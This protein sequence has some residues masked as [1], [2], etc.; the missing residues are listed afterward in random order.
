MK[1]QQ[2]ILAYFCKLL[3]QRNSFPCAY[4]SVIPD[5]VD[6]HL[7]LKAKYLMFSF[8]CTLDKNNSNSLCQL[9]IKE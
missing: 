8:F 3:L 6:S 7:P 5:S 4:H 2:L 9:K 1:L